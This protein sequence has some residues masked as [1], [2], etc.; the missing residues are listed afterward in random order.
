V[1]NSGQFTQGSLPTGAQC[2]SWIRSDGWEPR[3]E[4]A[5]ANS[6][7]AAP[8]AAELAAFH[9]N[10]LNFQSGPPA[11]DFANVDGNYAGTTWQIIEWAACKW[12]V[13][14][15]DLAAEA[16]A[17]SEWHQT[18]LG[19]QQWNYAACTGGPWIG[20]EPWGGC[21]TS[22]GIIQEKAS[23]FNTM[24]MAATSTA[25]NLDFRAAFWRAC[26]DGDEQYLYNETPAAGY[27]TYANA[28]GYQRYWGCMGEWYSGGWDD[29]GSV[30]YQTTVQGFS[31]SRPWL[32]LPNSQVGQI[33]ITSPQ[34]GQTVSGTVQISF[35]MPDGGDPLACY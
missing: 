14:A 10:P 29:P 15:Y 22:F 18:T 31:A 32:N 26:I 33:A 2:A 28:T 13:N 35:V 23:G 25:F 30:S 3:P 34:R 20:W 7:S 9:A 24:P 8:S 11:S 5:F 21:W 6:W 1:S 17:E 16:W 4:N 12:G 27:P 19:D